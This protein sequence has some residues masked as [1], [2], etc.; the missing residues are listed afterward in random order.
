VTVTNVPGYSTDSVAQHVF[1]LLLALVGRVAEH[2]AAVAEGH[3]S[4]SADFTFR[5][6]TTHELA[7]QTLGLIGL[8]AIGARVAQ[9]ALAFGMKVLAAES[10]RPSG[11]LALDGVRRVPLAELLAESD[12]V[13][14]HC[15]LTS[16]NRHLIDARRLGQMKRGALLVNT[17]RGPLLDSAAVALALR[18]GQLGGA[19]V[20]VLET[21]PPHADDPLLTAPNCLVTPHI[22]WGT[23]EARHRLMAIVTDN[24][25]AFLQGRPRNVVRAS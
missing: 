14:L 2:H 23:V 17:G 11:A 1:A 6:A 3:W 13:S 7:G 20:D 19:A 24:Y 25:R 9:I 21:E 10:S 8:G 22:A 18:S 4:S 16:H 15:P 12:V 5:L